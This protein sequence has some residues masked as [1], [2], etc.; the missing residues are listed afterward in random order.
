MYMPSGSETSSQQ[1]F[2]EQLTLTPARIAPPV[3]NE[4]LAALYREDRQHPVLLSRPRFLTLHIVQQEA[5]HIQQEVLH[6]QQEAPHIQREALHIVGQEALHIQQEA[7]HIQREAP[8]IQQQEAS[9]LCI[10]PSCYKSFKS[11]AILKLHRRK[12]HKTLR[13]TYCDKEY[14]SYVGLR[15]HSQTVHKGRNEAAPCSIC[16]EKFRAQQLLNQHVKRGKCGSKV[17][18]TVVAACSGRFRDKKALQRHQK[19]CN[20]CK[21]KWIPVPYICKMTTVNM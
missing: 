21:T 14:T 5:L 19:K 17:A 3:S 11:R 7:L 12:C 20:I 16:G 8:H 13:C 10:D 4:A 6:I 1:W 2:D 18:N 15:Y 9:H